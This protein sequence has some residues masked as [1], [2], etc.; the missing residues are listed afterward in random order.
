[1][2]RTAA[3]FH[4]Y[5]FRNVLLL[6]AQAE[7]RGV[8]I[9][10]VAG[11]RTWLSLGRHVRKGER[12]LKVLAPCR[13]RLSEEEAAKLGRA[14]VDADGRPQMVIRGFKIEHVFDISQT[15]GE[16][17]PEL[18]RP[19]TLTGEAPRGLWQAVAD[20]VAQL[21][22]EVRREQPSTPGAL[23]SVSWSERLVR[24]GP[25][26]DDA[27]ACKTLLH[28]LGHIEADHEHRAISKQ[29]RETEAESVAYIVGQLHGLDTMTYSA[30][31]VAGWSG[32]DL[33]VIQEA[34]E[35]VHSAARAILAALAEAADIEPM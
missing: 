17:L 29:Q 6:W 28:E 7:E 13:Y 2:L 32:G 26:V 27:Q 25:N 14:A 31:Y 23:G 4:T 12:G 8:Q 9:T 20:R 15:D 30:P 19:A 21:G 11:Y 33:E 1:M 18:P 34:A 3:R 24:V 16:P 10:Q 5:S 35:V 22:F